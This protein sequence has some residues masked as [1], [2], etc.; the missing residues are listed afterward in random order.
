MYIRKT[1]YLRKRN[2]RKW[3]TISTLRFVV[4]RKTLTKA[5][6]LPLVLLY[7]NWLNW[8]LLIRRFQC[9]I[10]WLSM[11]FM[12]FKY[13]FKINYQSPIFFDA[14]MHRL[15]KYCLFASLYIKRGIIRWENIFW[16]IFVYNFK[17]KWICTLGSFMYL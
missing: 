4:V 17:R 10:S 6:Y 5:A 3:I 14:V 7:T 1:Q 8:C 12:L 15:M 13:N 11:Q 16:L 2:P 9:T